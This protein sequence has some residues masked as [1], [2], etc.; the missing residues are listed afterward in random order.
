MRVFVTGATGFIGSHF[1]ERALTAGIEVVAHRR[2]PGSRPRIPLSSQPRWLDKPLSAISEWDFSGCE[3]LVHLAAAGV[4]PQPAD[5][6]SCYQVNVLDWLT[7]MRTAIRAGVRRFIVTGTF[8]E[9][10][11]A[12]QRFDAIP[13]DAPLEP[14][15]PYASSKACASVLSAALARA[16]NVCLSYL[17]LFSVFGEGQFENNLWP[18]LRIA[19]STGA[20]YPMTRGEQVRDFISVTSV[21]TRLLDECRDGSVQPGVPRVANLGTGEPQTV[22]DFADHWWREWQAAGQ[23]LVGAL[24]YRRDEVMRYVPAVDKKAA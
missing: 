8:A 2:S 10:G 12:G 1:V 7:L 17:R 20:D 3:A 5:W 19:A 9:Y 13:P 23:L 11:T 24:P 14:A 22:L 18:S 16:E 6:E 4:S 15:G 21:A